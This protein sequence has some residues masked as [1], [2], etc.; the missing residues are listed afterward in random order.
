MKHLLVFYCLFSIQAA[1]CEESSIDGWT[2]NF[3][4]SKITAN[5]YESL[6]EISDTD[7]YNDINITSSASIESLLNSCSIIKYNFVHVPENIAAKIISA[8]NYIAALQ[9]IEH[10]VIFAKKDMTID[11]VKKIGVLVNS[12]ASIFI[13]R[14]MEKLHVQWKVLEFDSGNTLLNAFLTQ[15]VDGFVIAE[16]FINALSRQIAKNLH[17]IHLFEMEKKTLVLIPKDQT[18]SKTDFIL[19]SLMKNHDLLY[20]NSLTTYEENTNNKQTER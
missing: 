5:K 12:P 9:S 16:G 10:P 17:K 6:F 1:F 19:K 4:T 18:K 14:E 3:Y 8:C 20:L 2:Y 15:E 11:R 13:W 7:L